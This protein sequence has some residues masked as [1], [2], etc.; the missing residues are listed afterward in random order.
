MDAEVAI[1]FRPLAEDDL[2]LVVRWLNTPHVREWWQHDPRTIEEARA[3][4]MPRIEGAEP[5]AAYVILVGGR[6]IGY[7][8]AYRIAD[9]PEYAGAVDVEE[10]AAGGDLF[11]GDEGFVHR[12]L[13][14]PIL[15]AFLR[16]VVFR[17]PGVMCCVIGP[18]AGNAIAIR[19]YEKAGFRHLKTV[20]VPGE[21][22]PEYLMRIAPRDLE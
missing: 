21:D 22:E 7:I 2:P 4:Y 10:G 6:P 11:I 8:Q 16:D 17:M 5:T 9:W 12:G 14:A 18:S 13:G 20:A 1:T 19:A 15:R 3:K